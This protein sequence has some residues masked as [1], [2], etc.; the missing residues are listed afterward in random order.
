MKVLLIILLSVLFTVPAFSQR[1]SPTSKYTF[2]AIDNKV[3][4]EIKVRYY[5]NAKGFIVPD[6][7]KLL[8]GLGFG[9]DEIEVEKFIEKFKTSKEN[10]KGLVDAFGVPFVEGP[11]V[12]TRIV[13]QKNL[14]AELTAAEWA[15]YNTIKGDRLL[16]AGNTDEALKSY[17][18][19]LRRNAKNARAYY[20]LAKIYEKRGESE[21]A[22]QALENAKKYK[23]EEPR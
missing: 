7:V 18:T 11:R 5:L 19:A 23:E 6:S 13:S 4:G 12:S 16:E 8:K 10:W 14:P 9:L 21:R 22:K 1:L 3:K 17:Q 15:E 20:G 2:E